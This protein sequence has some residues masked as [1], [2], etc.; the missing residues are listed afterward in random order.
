MFG[1]IFKLSV[2]LVLVL[3]IGERLFAELTD[4]LVHSSGNGPSSKP[5]S[6]RQ[7]KQQSKPQSKRQSE[8]EP[9][10]PSTTNWLY[11]ETADHVNYILTTRFD[12]YAGMGPV[13]RPQQHLEIIA[14]IAD[15]KAANEKPIRFQPG[16]AKYEKPADELI[17]GRPIELIQL[18]RF[19]QLPADLALRIKAVLY[20]VLE[21]KKMYP[22][23][24]SEVPLPELEYS[25]TPEELRSFKKAVTLLIERALDLADL[26]VFVW[27]DVQ[28]TA[29]DAIRKFKQSQLYA[30]DFINAKDVEQ[31][32]LEG[33]KP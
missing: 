23:L 9:Q 17:A 29:A 7:S 33:A 12:N 14:I 10:A 1:T 22:S 11:G 24:N 30:G 6:K 26:P 31:W 3:L 32:V 15:L 20:R 5:Q 13:G 2:I 8:S 27:E 4:D 21:E 18:N 16:T 25:H 19:H 28:A